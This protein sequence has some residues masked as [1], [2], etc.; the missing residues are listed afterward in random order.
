MTPRLKKWLTWTGYPLAYICLLAFFARLTFPFE[1]LRDRLVGEFNA[2]QAPSARLR[3]GEMSGYWLAGV[4]ASKIELTQIP[5]DKP[6]QAT[7]ESKPKTTL[8]DSAHVSVSLIRALFGTTAISFGAAAFGGELSGNVANSSSEQTYDLDLD[9]LDV[10]QVPFL[11]ELVGLP[12]KGTLAGETELT[13]PERSWSKCEGKVE[14]T[15]GGLRVGDGKA[16]VLNAIALPEINV[17]SID[18]SATATAGRLKVDK[19]V[20]KG[21]DLDL[22]VDG[23]I[24]FRDPLGTSLLDLS[25]K[26]KFSDK[27]RNKNDTTRALLGAPGSTSPALFELT[28][29]VQ[30]SKRPDGYYGWHIGGTLDHPTFDPSATSSA[31]PARPKP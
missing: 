23:N 12:M 1:R 13:L 20:A 21:S 2:Q 25:L 24:R 14:F 9:K 18:F 27:Y 6:A 30:R 31:S 19:F 16:K 15:F 5:K 17:G 7:T 26:F 22:G 4:E 28:P 11:D 29:Q 3:I 8:V 10:G